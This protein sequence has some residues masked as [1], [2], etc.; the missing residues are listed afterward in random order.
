MTYIHVAIPLNIS[1]FSAQLD[2]LKSHLAL[3]HDSLNNRNKIGISLHVGKL[4]TIA[5]PKL[6]RL[7]DKI[8]FIDHILPDDSLQ[9]TVSKRI[10][11]FYPLMAELLNQN[12]T[13][14]HHLA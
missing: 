12:N 14:S 2:L 11:R 3:M 7:I 1:S 9:I 8:H 4:L 5:Q 10:K 13:F 6:Y